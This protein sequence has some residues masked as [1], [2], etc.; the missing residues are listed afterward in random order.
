M[1]L[2]GA[3]SPDMSGLAD[4]ERVSVSCQHRRNNIAWIESHQTLREHPKTYSLA[5][6]LNISTATAVGHLH[7]LWWWCLD[8]SHNGR[9]KADDTK[10]IARAA[11]WDGDA[12]VFCDSM[13]SAGFLDRCD[14][15]DVEIHDWFKFAGRLIHA[16]EKDAKRKQDFRRTSGGHPADG[17]RTAGVQYS[18][19]PNNTQPN[20]TKP[21]QEQ[22]SKSTP[23]PKCGAGVSD[24]QEK[25]FDRFWDAYPRHVN[26]KRARELFLKL[27]PPVFD[28]IFKA[29]EVQKKSEAWT[30]DGGK[31][32]PHPTTWINGKRWEDEVGVQPVSAVEG[33]RPGVKAVS[34]FRSA[35]EILQGLGVEA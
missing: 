5:D 10:K 27:N 12:C 33:N 34:G 9:F 20:Q 31:F 22:K 23:A 7:F 16:R 3:K 14:G 30:K 18:T 26:K 32:I 11:G 6:A 19:Q 15:G 24:E 17:E 2:I 21:N 25:L 35:K 29:L 13:V 1:D 28:A 8:Y 4:V